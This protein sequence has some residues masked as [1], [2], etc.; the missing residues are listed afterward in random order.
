M[1]RRSLALAVVVLVALAFGW[2]VWPTRYEYV[3]VHGGN[4]ERVVRIDRITGK[5]FERS[6]GGWVPTD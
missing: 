1:H 6:R 2:F 4:Y 3:V 5:L